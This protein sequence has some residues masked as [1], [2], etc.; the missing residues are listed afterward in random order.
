MFLHIVHQGVKG[1][2]SLTLKKNQVCSFLSTFSHNYFADKEKY[3][4]IMAS[5]SQMYQLDLL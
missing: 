2:I 3:V 4:K 1:F 5:S